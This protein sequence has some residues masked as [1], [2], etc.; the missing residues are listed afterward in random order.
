MDNREGPGPEN[1]FWAG[2]GPNGVY[3]WFIHYY[4]PPPGERYKGP[5]KWRVRIKHDGKVQEFRG[6][7]SQ[8]HDQSRIYTFRVGGKDD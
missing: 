3:K 6:A 7:L 8:V 5:A 2:R 4:G 1:I